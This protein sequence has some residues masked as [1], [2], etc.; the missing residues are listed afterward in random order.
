[1]NAIPITTSDAVGTS[2]NINLRRQIRV[3]ESLIQAFLFFCA[4][5]SILTTIG[6]VIILFQESLRFFRSPEVSLIQFF[7]TTT[8]QPKLGQFGIGPCSQLP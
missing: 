1:M 5:V 4:A 7:T 6:I 3:G 2:E 8:W